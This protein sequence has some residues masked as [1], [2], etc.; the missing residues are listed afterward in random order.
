[1]CDIIARSKVPKLKFLWVI[2]F[3]KNC[4]RTSFTNLLS[5]CYSFWMVFGSS[6]R[7]PYAAGYRVGYS[8]ELRSFFEVHFSRVF[9]AFVAK[10]IGAKSGVRRGEVLLIT[11]FPLK[12]ENAVFLSIFLLKRS[13]QIPVCIRKHRQ[14]TV[15]PLQDRFY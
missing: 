15:A 7:T 1:M 2:R 12:L 3:P 9:I 5:K 13:F 4:F 6:Y 11:P 8:L 14:D 10:H